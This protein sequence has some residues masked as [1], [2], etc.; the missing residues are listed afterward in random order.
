LP[1]ATLFTV[2]HEDLARL[3]PRKAVDFFRDLLWAEAR[4]IGLPT[5]RVRVSSRI[6]VAD[7]DVDAAV[8][9]D[10][11]ESTDILKN[12]RTSYQIKASDEFRPWQR[13]VIKEE[14]FGRNKEPARE[15][16]VLLVP[17]RSSGTTRRTGSVSLGA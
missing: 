17:D 6:Y 14:L 8:E 9:G 16:H 12:G 3:D 7:G 11:P 13:S 4:R 5:S 2:G 1:V 10:L 15:N